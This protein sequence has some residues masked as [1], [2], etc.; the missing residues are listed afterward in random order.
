ME[1]RARDVIFFVA[2]L[3]LVAAAILAATHG[4]LDEAAAGTQKKGGP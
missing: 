1:A 2:A 4:Y 3:I